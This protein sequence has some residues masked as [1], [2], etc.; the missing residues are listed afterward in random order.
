MLRR[1]TPFVLAL[2]LA[3]AFAT[4]TSAAGVEPGV[5]PSAPQV[6]APGVLWLGVV[7]AGSN[8][9]EGAFPPGITSISWT[10]DPNVRPVPTQDGHLFEYRSSDTVA[11]TTSESEETSS[12]GE[13]AVEGGDMAEEIDDSGAPYVFGCRDIEMGLPY[14]IRDR[15]NI[16]HVKGYTR[17]SSCINLREINAQVCL[18]ANYGTTVGC[19]ANRFS[20]WPWRITAEVVCD[21][22]W[23]RNRFQTWYIATYFSLRGPSYTATRISPDR[24]HACEGWY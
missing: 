17:W 9:F 15:F 21:Y 19:R 12:E 23:Q 11:A 13:V 10:T 18:R 5:A 24:L 3:L 22:T 14:R 20:G 4:P 2:A 16:Y 7:S 8:P 1:A 6:I